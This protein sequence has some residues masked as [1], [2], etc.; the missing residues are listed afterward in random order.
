MIARSI[1]LLAACACL[2]S[3]SSGKRISQANDLLRR[4]NHDLE[5]EVVALKRR[6]AELESEL[7]VAASQPQEMTAELRAATP[8]IAE[9]SIGRLTHIRDSDKNGVPDTLVVYIHPVDGRGRFTQMVGSIT[10]T[11]AIVPDDGDAQTIGRVLLD[12][13]EVRDAYRS[14]FTGQHYVAEIPVMT[15]HR[16]ASVLVRIAFEDGLTGQTLSAE[17]S[18]KIN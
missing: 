7:K 5:Q 8:R 17:R 6:N 12:P 2:F 1:A 13:V 4:R 11:A 10:A 16:S 3:C 14:S 18:I 15:D 9:I